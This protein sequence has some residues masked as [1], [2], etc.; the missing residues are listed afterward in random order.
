M[1]L[2]CYLYAC[3]LT[4]SVARSQ[5]TV[6]FMNRFGPEVD[7]PFFDEQGVLL[8][9]SAYLAQL[10]FWNADVGFGPAAGNPVVFSTNG[11]FF[12]E[13]VVL[14]FV[15]ECGSAWVQVRA[16]EA[17]GGETFEEA[18]LAGA[19]TGVSTILF[20]QPLGSP[21]RP[22]ACRHAPLIGLKYPGSPIVLQQPQARTIL[23]GTTATLGVIASSGVLMSYQWYKQPS[24]LPDGL[25][26]GAT[27]ATY[28][29]PALTNDSSFWVSVT[30][31]AGSVLS[32]EATVRV[33]D[34][35]PRL[36]LRQGAGLPMLTLDASV[37]LPYRIEYKADLGTT[38][39]SRLVDLSLHSSPFSFID[40]GATDSPVRFYRAV[41]P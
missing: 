27:N 18:A 2:L 29:T 22:E 23:A 1:R 24:D 39:W 37:G 8:E 20:L 33:L 3:C 36:S 6:W 7:A 17:Q 34:A 16:W 28:T 9:G 38:N 13:S 40:S 21:G 26:P 25:I 32:N 5:G 15:P 4:L 10:Y 14:P 41:A 11:W 31:S 30:N 35:A 12:G 19:W